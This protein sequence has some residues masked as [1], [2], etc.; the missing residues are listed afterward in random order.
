[1][2]ANSLQEAAEENRV[3]GIEVDGNVLQRILGW[4]DAD[5]GI[6]NA[7]IVDGS[8]VF[9]IAHPN[10]KP[11]HPENNLPMGMAVY[12]QPSNE[13]NLKFSQIILPEEAV[14]EE[15]VGQV[16][17]GKG[18]VEKVRQAMKSD[19]EMKQEIVDAVLD[20]YQNGDGNE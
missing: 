20:E 11:H 13:D 1:M 7:T 2:N 17:S 14:T 6:V 19:P 12:I 15:I 9:I 18:L 5:F 8:M 4:E 10:F 3:V 16:S